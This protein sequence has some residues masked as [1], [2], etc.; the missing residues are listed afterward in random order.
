MKQSLLTLATA[1]LLLISGCAS[2]GS[3]GGNGSSSNNGEKA[4]NV[5]SKRNIQRYT[6]NKV[7]NDHNEIQFQFKRAGMENISNIS[8]INVT[9]TSGSQRRQM[10][11]VIISSVD[12]PYTGEITYQMTTKYKMRTR[13]AKM[14]FK[15]NEPGVW[16]ITLI[17]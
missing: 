11:T 16:K 15:I 5:T 13:D 8:Q 10:N 7:S 4:Y 3:A 17:N 1:S 9:G 6:F 14:E 12:Y 2:S